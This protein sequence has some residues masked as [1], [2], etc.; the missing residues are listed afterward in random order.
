MDENR[1]FESSSKG[2]RQVQSM[3]KRD[4]NHPSVI[5]YSIFNNE[6][7]LQGTPQGR[8]MANRIIHT[9]KKLD[10]TRFVT[11]A[12]DGDLLEDEGVAE[13]FILR[14]LIIRGC[15]IFCVN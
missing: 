13:Y 10:K 12:M 6:E 15:K 1:R 5:I 8:A 3:V 14:D 2:L 11:A 7:P 4:R 9:I